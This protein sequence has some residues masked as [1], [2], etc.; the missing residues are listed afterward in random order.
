MDDA[1]IQYWFNTTCNE[2]VGGN[3]KPNCNVI[4]NNNFLTC[5]KTTIDVALALFTGPAPTCGAPN[6]PSLSEAFNS[7]S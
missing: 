7:M 4:A 5:I 6:L 3:E 1:E 2:V